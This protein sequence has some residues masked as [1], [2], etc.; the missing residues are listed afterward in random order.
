MTVQLWVP[1]D[2]SDDISSLVMEKYPSIRGQLKKKKLRFI[3]PKVKI[4]FKED[5]KSGLEVLKL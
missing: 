5:I 2:P 1:D 3:M 4:S